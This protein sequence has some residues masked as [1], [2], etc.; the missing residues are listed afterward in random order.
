MLRAS[1]TLLVLAAAALG[2]P[3]RAA[4]Q[5]AA[6]P[7]LVDRGFNLGFVNPPVGSGR[8]MGLGGAFSALATGI[9]GASWNP[10]AI[11]AREFWS[12]GWFTWDLSADVS[13]A[14]FDFFDV[15]TKQQRGY[16]YGKFTLL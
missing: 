12:T 11:A 15:N 16:A 6:R 9:D 4:A 3:G 8:V 7:P 13:V 5:A 14:L 10:A 1:G 2:S